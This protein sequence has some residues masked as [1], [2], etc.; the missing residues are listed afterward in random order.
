MAESNWPM[1]VAVS[2]PIAAMLV[3]ALVERHRHNSRDARLLA[4]MAVGAA[5]LAGGVAGWVS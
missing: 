2:L 4:A 5:A 3:A 1:L